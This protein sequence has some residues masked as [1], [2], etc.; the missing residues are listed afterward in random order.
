MARQT[1]EFT[2]QEREQATMLASFALPDDRIAAFLGC[3]E[4]TLQKRCKS[5]LS[6][7]RL[8]SNVRVMTKLYQLA[9]G[10]S[11]PACIFWLKARAG[12]RENGESEKIDLPTL[13][14]EIE[15]IAKQ[16]ENTR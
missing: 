13:K 8:I 11:V 5:E 2:E 9:V 3:S 16:L 14:I 1:R 7:G 12:W 10:G 6:R 4:R 15:S